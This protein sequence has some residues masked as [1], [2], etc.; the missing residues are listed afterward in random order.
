MYRALTGLDPI[1]IVFKKISLLT[2]S[3]YF[4]KSAGKGGKARTDLPIFDYIESIRKKEP[5]DEDAF[6]IKLADL[7][8]E[9]EH[10]SEDD[11]FDDSILPVLNN[12]SLDKEDETILKKIVLKFHD[13][14]QKEIMSESKLLSVQ[15]IDMDL[16]SFCLYFERSNSQGVNLT[17]TDI[18]TAKVYLGFKLSQ[19]ILKAQ[20]D[21]EHLKDETALK[22]N[23]NPWWIELIIRYL[24]Y[25]DHNEVTRGSILK[26]SNCRFI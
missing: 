2:S 16:E 4:D 17:F 21:H 14:F 26:K 5:K 7:F 6:Y 25:L 24:N 18:I 20:D 10:K 3:E 15:L 8:H 9:G 23:R 22:R 12:L 1:F 19:H 11:I 13:S